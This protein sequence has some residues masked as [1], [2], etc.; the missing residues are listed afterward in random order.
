ME[1][2]LMMMDAWRTKSNKLFETYKASTT[3]PG[4][5][6]PEYIDEVVSGLRHAETQ[7]N[8]WRESA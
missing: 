1:T 7:F 4:L 8:R 6:T 5:F 2:P 3:A